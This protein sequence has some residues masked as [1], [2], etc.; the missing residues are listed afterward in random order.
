MTVGHQGALGSVVNF[1]SATVIFNPNSTGGAQALA[2]QLRRDV[3]SR[4][5][6]LSVQLCGTERAGHAVELAEAAARRGGSLIVSVSGDGGYHEVVNGVM[7]AGDTDAV[8]AVLAA[9]NANDHRRIT[10]RGPLIDAIVS[11]RA[12]PVDLLRFS[13]STAGTS[14][15]RYA[16]SYIGLGLT[17]LVALSLDEGKKGSLREL[18]TSIKAFALS[19]PFEID[20]DKGRRRSLDSLVLANIAEMAKYATLSS[21]GRP[22]DGVFE[23]I[24]LPHRSKAATMMTAL[25]AVTRGL[26]QQPQ[27]REFRFTTV[28]SVP[29]QLDGEADVLT[30]GSTVA[31][32]IAP[33]ALS[34]IS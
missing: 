7:R 23:L 21:A 3:A 28:G 33:Q 32:T 19:R 5:P 1:R 6:E 13:T 25:K 26:G 20:D 16:H 14:T 34:V 15:V 22:D 11:G 27:V 9:G 12:H 4:L 18:A 2:E 31:V 30:G 10:R 17:A 24:A 8:C 29:V